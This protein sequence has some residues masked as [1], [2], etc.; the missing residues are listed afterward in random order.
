MRPQPKNVPGA[1]ARPGANPGREQCP[2][3]S[4]G[5]KRRSSRQV[6]GHAGHQGGFEAFSPQ[7]PRFWV[8]VSAGSWAGLEEPQAVLGSPNPSPESALRLLHPE[9]NQPRAPYPSIAELQGG[10]GASLSFPLLGSSSGLL[11]GL[12]SCSPSLISLLTKCWSLSSAPWGCTCPRLPGEISCSP[13]LA[14]LSLA[15]LLS[16]PD[17]SVCSTESREGDKSTSA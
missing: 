12:F 5:W 13:N 7:L 1:A 11:W 4:S 2:A 3:L 14:Q 10:F 9:L 15:G 6:F 8:E 16:S 17:S